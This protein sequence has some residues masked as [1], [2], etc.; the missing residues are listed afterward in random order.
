MSVLQRTVRQ[1]TPLLALMFAGLALS[2]GAHAQDPAAKIDITD[3]G[4]SP[5][6]VA[7]PNGQRVAIEVHNRTDRPMEFESYDLN[8]EKLVPGGSLVRLWV[9]PL[10]SGRYQFFDDFNPEL[11]GT[12]VVKEK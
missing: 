7:V 6:T 2:E 1:T 3:Q 5:T 10:D 9:G 4:F 11:T 8:R 12:I